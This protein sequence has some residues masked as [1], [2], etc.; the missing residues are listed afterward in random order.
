MAALYRHICEACGKDEVLTADEGF[1]AGWDYP[2][3]MGVFG[4]LSPRTCGDCGIDS[5]LWWRLTTG[6]TTAATLTEADHTLLER[7]A[8]EPES[9][10]VAGKA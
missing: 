4:V 1:Q 7:V 6:V 9:I 8:Q 5:T 3:A 2:P 10:L